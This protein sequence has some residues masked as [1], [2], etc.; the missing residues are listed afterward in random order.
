MK[1]VS[2]C[3]KR[4]YQIIVLE[5]LS[6]NPSKVFPMTDDFPADV[7]VPFIRFQVSSVI[8]SSYTDCVF[9]LNFSGL[10][11]LNCFSLQK[12]LSTL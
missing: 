6:M 7:K 2:E 10:V 11:S 12:M 3:N 9:I 1:S 5:K 8:N 4:V